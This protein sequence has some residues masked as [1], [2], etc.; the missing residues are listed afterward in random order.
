MVLAGK[1][2]LVTGGSS[3]LG[4]SIAKKLLE[5][6]CIVYILGRN[7]ESLDHAKGELN[8]PN[9]HTLCGDIRNYQQLQE[10]VQ[11]LPIDIVINN[12][13]VWLEGTIENNT[14]EEIAEA[15]DTNL[16]GAI[17]TTKA[18]LPTMLKKNDGYIINI[19][20][21]SGL[22]GR[23]DQAIYVAS[24]FGLS[25][26]TK[27]LELDLAKTNIKVTGFYPGGM[28]TGLFAKTENPKRNEDWMDTNKIADILTFILERDDTMVISS[29]EVNKRGTKVSNK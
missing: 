10:L 9:I 13:G 12:A 26:F 7:Q 14:E 17:Y 19:I 21:T 1:V 11:E 2:A 15:I 6:D 16:K 28:H 5:K 18:V 25:G 27:S 4:F 3:G 29:I 8:S 20:S 24:K 22:K 23:E